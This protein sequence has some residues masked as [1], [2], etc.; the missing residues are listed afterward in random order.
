MV[1]CI[2]MDSAPETAGMWHCF[3]C[4]VLFLKIKSDLPRGS[5]QNKFPTLV[6]LGWDSGAMDTDSLGVSDFL[7][8]TVKSA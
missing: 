8:I 1:N 3:A 6:M 4:K 7:S 5:I 2:C